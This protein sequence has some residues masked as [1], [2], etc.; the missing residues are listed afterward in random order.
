VPTSYRKADSPLKKGFFFKKA[1]FFQIY[2][3]QT[4]FVGLQ[5]VYGGSKAIKSNNSRPM[6]KVSSDYFIF[7][8]ELSFWKQHHAFV[9]TNNLHVNVFTDDSSWSAARPEQRRIALPPLTEHSIV[10]TAT[11]DLG[12]SYTLIVGGFSAYMEDGITPN[13]STYNRNIYFSSDNGAEWFVRGPRSQAHFS[14]PNRPND[15][16]TPRSGAAIFVYKRVQLTDT[17][18]FVHGGRY[19]DGHNWGNNGALSDIWAIHLVPCVH[20]YRM[21]S[22]SNPHEFVHF[23]EDCLM[24]PIVTNPAKPIAR[25]LHQVS[26]VQWGGESYFVVI[27][28]FDANGLASGSG[29]ND[30]FTTY[31]CTE[32]SLFLAS[33]NKLELSFDQLDVSVNALAY[34]A[35]SLSSYYSPTL[36]LFF[37]FGG[38]TL[39]F[40][41]PDFTMRSHL[42]INALQVFNNL[43]VF[44][45]DP[46]DGTSYF[47]ELQAIGT[48]PSGR[49][50]VQ[51]FTFNDQ[52][53]FYGGAS[54]DLHIHA[55]VFSLSISSAHPNFTEVSGDA[56]SG[57]VVGSISNLFVSAQTITLLPALSCEASFFASV[58]S[59]IPGFPSY[60]LAF[61][62]RGVDEERQAAIY[63]SSFIPIV[64]GTYVIT[65]STL[66]SS[67]DGGMPFIQRI[68]ILPGPT[69]AST[70]K[71]E[72]SDT[73]TAGSN[74]KFLVQCI[75]AFSNIRPGG[76][77]IQATVFR[78]Q[79]DSEGNDLRTSDQFSFGYTDLKSGSHQLIASFTRSGM[80]LI[81]STLGVRLI[82]DRPFSFRVEPKAALCRQS[83]DVCNTL[84]ISALDTVLAGQAKSMQVI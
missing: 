63:H 24:R 32:S 23:Q 42:S 80:F 22:Q 82:Q 47:E 71:L 62:S 83:P 66:G 65:V 54:K 40:T 7:D 61:E 76:D 28:G 52:V 56:L 50:G 45:F 48:R 55:T 39:D 2:P 60:D 35:S 67:I 59:E 36:G 26:M 75:D 5:I 64:S 8:P 10:S 43:M 57:G 14:D 29:T 21:P 31:Y 34:F 73:V 25:Y 69:C 51:L 81:E 20:L 19:F 74:A 72:Y 77:I 38:S 53:Y 27:G 3:F 41:S 16:I 6:F 33:D 12:I 44:R 1:T 17:L 68:S 84:V 18:V 15:W 78:M 37:L 46:K 79:S 9:Y 11:L 70:S 4:V 58:R 49:A 13:T 30:T